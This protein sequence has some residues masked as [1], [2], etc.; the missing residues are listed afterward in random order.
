MAGRSW[1]KEDGSPMTQA[2]Y[3]NKAVVQKLNPGPAGGSSIA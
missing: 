3:F 1:K 2:D